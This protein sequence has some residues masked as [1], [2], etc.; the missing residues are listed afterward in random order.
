MRFSQAGAVSALI[1]TTC[2]ALPG[3]LDAQ[4]LRDRIRDRARQQAEQRAEERA[5][6]AVDRA[7]DT[8]EEGIRCVFTDAECI[9]RAEASGQAVIFT[10][11]G[12]NRTDAGGRPTDPA[13]L[14]PGE[15]VW[16]NYDFVPGD[17][18]LFYE[19]F[20][21]D[22]VGNFPRRLEFRGGNLEIV[23]WEGRRLLRSTS[24]AGRFAIPLAEL[25]PDRFTIEFLYFATTRWGATAVLTGPW[26]GPPGTYPG[27]Y[28]SLHGEAGV[29]HGGGGPEAVIHTLRHGEGMTPVRIMVDGSYVKMYLGEER[30]AN[31]PNATILRSDRPV[32]AFGGHEAHP[33]FIGEIRISGGGEPI[34][35]ALLE[36][37]RVSLRGILFE[38]GSARIQPESTPTLLEIGELLTRRPELRIR[39]EGHTDSV[40]DAASNQALSERRAEA[41]RAFLL[42]SA[43]IDA[44]RLEAVGLGQGS[45]VD[46]NDT[47]EGRQNNRRVELVRL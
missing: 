3:V 38:T 29:R 18:V 23:D 44:S 30:V 41:V 45:P 16:A 26:D 4:G 25:L 21:G 17:V 14:A 5:A 2:L 36:H 32:F 1:V 19:D 7:L 42:R 24:D 27:S 15:G 28:P 12:G 46:V 47:P 39:I 9:A 22:R 13:A 10:D 31:I 8:A 20:A 6:Q 43:G 37:G 40:G 11:T 34:Y 35:D 33:A